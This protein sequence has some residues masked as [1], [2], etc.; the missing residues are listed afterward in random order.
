M[1]HARRVALV[2][3]LAL[4]PIFLWKLLLTNRILVGLDAFNFFYPYHDFAAS[5]LR[6]GRLPLWNPH[7]FLGVPF[8]ADSQAQLLYPP[9]WPLLWLDAPRALNLSIVLHL[10]IAALGMGLLGRRAL[11]LGCGGAWVAGTVFVLGGYLGSQVE[12]PNQL[13]AAAWLPWLLLG[14]TVAERR[15][16]RGL[17]LTALALALSLLAGHAQTTFISLAALGFWLLSGFGV[18]EI[19]AWSVE[20]GVLGRR[21]RI[22]NRPFRFTL[23]PL[24]SIVLGLALAAVQLVPMAELS[25][26]SIRAAGLSYREAVSFSFDPRLWPRALLPTFGQDARLLSEFVAYIGFSGALLA[27]VGLLFARRGR[28]WTWALALAVTGLLLAPAVVNPLSPLLWRFVPGVALF[29]VPARWLLLYALGA[30]VLAGLGADWLLARSRPLDRRAWRRLGEALA[31][32]GLLA[33]GSLVV[34]EL[35]RPAVWR[36]WAAALAASALLLVLPRFPSRVRPLLL[37]LVVGG[38]L[39][40]ASRGLDYNKPTAPEAY[41]GLRPAPAHLLTVQ[42]PAGQPRLLSR[43]DLTWDPGDLAELEARHAGVLG[44]E[45]AY[46]L[47]VATKLKEVLAPNQPLRWG[48]STADGYG[49]GLLPLRS[50][51]MLQTLLPLTKVVPDGRLRERLT[52]VPARR[53][54][55]LLGVEWI[56]ADKVA[57]LWVEGVYHDL[58]LARALQPGERL[59]WE[60][61][62]PFPADGVSLVAASP[63]PP[64]D[65][66]QVR[67]NTGPWLAVPA[68]AF[69]PA[70]D[71]WQRARV[72]LPKTV[73]VETLELRLPP[74]AAGWTLGA[75]TLT[76][77]RLAAFEALPG[78]PAFET[79]LS[80]DVK[81]YRRRDGLGRAWAVP[82]ARV[83]SPADLPAALAAPGFDPRREVLL[84]GNHE[85][86]PLPAAPLTKATVAWLDETPEALSLRVTTDGAGWLVLADNWFPGWT[87]TVDGRT[88]RIEP[89]N[90]FARAVAI[91]GPG[92]H[93]VCFRYRPRSVVLGALITALALLVVLT[94]VWREWISLPARR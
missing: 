78:D 69:Q 44:P 29:R 46:D 58:G 28:T 50:Y 87:V 88:A 83:V 25:R 45:A 72:T 20:I 68:S 77:S 34:A 84:T 15:P 3:L 38:E 49:G 52:A 26:L 90:L 65:L 35:P 79:A 31:L 62:P 4:P 94:L 60:V 2:S 59:R 6:A 32:G 41:T 75:L 11:G 23:L 37:A 70:R 30:A 91:P 71:Q 93:A 54:L 55:D 12:H 48:L 17:I 82:A 9:N 92:V 51:T 5:A 24:I 39:F 21:V 36:W 43:S 61:R 89:A 1:I 14:A 42:P 18:K 47:V 64:G 86:A 81:V 66:G 63:L 73:T 27:L 33:A 13:A 80:G 53:W 19:G 67:V 7:L 74:G 8:L 56:V 10:M 16:R 57:D 22:G 85:A 76:N 40:A